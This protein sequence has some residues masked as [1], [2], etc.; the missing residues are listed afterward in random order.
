MQGKVSQAMRF[1]SESSNIKGVY[2]SN[3]EI[4]QKLKEKHPEAQIP[5]SEIL[6]SKEYIAPEPV[7]FET[8]DSEVVKTAAKEIQGSGGPSKIDADFFK[9]ILCTKFYKSHSVN[10]CQAIA[11]LTK[12]LATEE[13]EPRHLRHFISGRLIP[14]KKD[15]SAEIK[16]RPIGIGEILRRITGKCIVKTLK[17][18]LQEASG[19]LQTCS[20]ISSGI[21][22]AIH[23]MRKTFNDDE[24][25]AMLLVD[26][27]NAFNSLNRAAAVHNLQ[28]LCPPFYRYIHNTYQCPA[29]LVV[30]GS[31]ED[32]H[33]SSEEGVTQGDVCAMALYGVSTKNIIMNLL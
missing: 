32:G 13:I 10:L 26:A 3:K 9:H 17:L 8:I 31:D 6:S 25:E 14:L 27:S 24:C 28:H 29:D 21:E 19:I 11:D 4:L 5:D 7:L 15:D 16:I 20:G 22:A 12:R 1:I 23:A 33:I 2:E 18:D 30:N